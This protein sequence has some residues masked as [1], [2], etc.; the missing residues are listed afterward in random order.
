[1]IIYLD[2]ES[3]GLMGK[4]NLIQLGFVDTE[5]NLKVKFL[6]PPKE[7]DKSKKLIETIMYNPDNTVIMY[8]A[9]HDLFKLYQ[10]FEFKEAFTAKTIDL[11]FR[12]K[13]DLLINNSKC[14]YLS[15]VHKEAAKVIADKVC[16]D[17]ELEIGL[18]IKASFHENKSKGAD[19]ELLNNISFHVKFSAKLKEIIAILKLD[20]SA[21]KIEETGWQIFKGKKNKE[22]EHIVTIPDD[23]IYQQK[24]D[25]NEAIL[26]DPKSVFWYYAT[27]DI[28]Y[29]K[30]LYDFFKQPQQDTD[31]TIS[32]IVAYTRYVGFELDMEAL[33]QY[34]VSIRNK[35][36]SITDTFDFDIASPKQRKEW[37]IKNGITASKTDK[38]TLIKLL[39]KEKISVELKDKIKLIVEYGAAHQRLTQAE[40]LFEAKKAHPNFRVIGTE[41]GRMSGTGGLNFQGIDRS[42]TGIR[43]CIKTSQGGDFDALELNI[44]AYAYNDQM[45]QNDLKQRDMHLQ[46]SLCMTDD[47]YEV[48]K[49]KHLDGDKEIKKIRQIG[50]TIN[51]SILYFC[52]QA[53]VEEVLADNDGDVAKAKDILKAFKARYKSITEASKKIESDFV[54]LT[55]DQFS[56]S[57]RAV[58]NMKD[59][60]TGML[61]TT[62]KFILE[63]AFCKYLITTPLE[64][65]VPEHLKYT[66]IT[67]QE[68]KGVQPVYNSIM[69]ARF[70]AT[71]GI[72][73]AVYRMGG[74]HIVQSTGADLTKRFMATLWKKYK[75]PM[76]NI[77]DEIIVPGGYEHLYNDI[78]ATIKELLAEYKSLIPT[79]NMDWNQMAKWSD[80]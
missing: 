58:Y 74:N 8:N 26:D 10:Q 65:L 66:N 33:G 27:K 51:F 40:K 52:T 5:G 2:T 79:L 35:I 7:F 16:T 75:I 13:K 24:F 78:Q 11:I 55:P 76:M 21:F 71:M 18:P 48:A 57:V 22:K 41:S 12:V 6:R 67:R 56:D 34:T 63:K 19:N 53:R 37:L 62:R 1:M 23:E 3:T 70:G 68:K 25:A 64:K 73:Q 31:D 59:S 46:T 47:S 45:M 32:E 4:L 29:L 42:A 38:K 43:N 77:H 49:Q 36:K 69:S 15:G 80:K 61:G 20:E 39:E 9:T 60:I 17:M 44:A 72:Q 28:E 14:V 50:K 54:T 30:L